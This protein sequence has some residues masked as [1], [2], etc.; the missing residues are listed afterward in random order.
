MLRY[1]IVFLHIPKTA[2]ST[3]QF[4]LEN[5]FGPS[6][7]HTNH[8]KKTVFRRDDLA[9]ARRAFPWIKSLAGHNLL[10]PSSLDLPG[11]FHM[12]FLRE[13]VARVLSHYQDTVLTGG[14]TWT[15]EEF[16]RQSDDA[17]NLH[18]RL[19]AGEPNLGKAK[20]YL[21]RCDFVGLTE[22]F[23]LSLHV[24]GKFSP[25]ALNLNYTRR[26]TALTNAI[27]N[28]VAAN[29]RM[30]QLARERNQLDLALHDFAVKEIFPRICAKAGFTPDSKV[31]SF[32]T[33]TTELHWR[34]QLCHLY[35]LLFYRHPGKLR[36]KPS[37][38]WE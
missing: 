37:L 23:D 3:F 16:M 2:G 38:A 22:R 30:I 15:F 24:L 26:R 33:Y 27:R 31:A 35:N 5:T 36:R 7:C 28:R 21:E 6:A 25:C 14:R 9:F 4:I 12:T 20:K 29:P 8:T 11:A 32:H 19:M 13:P 18:V 17:E 1:V 10:D 34:F